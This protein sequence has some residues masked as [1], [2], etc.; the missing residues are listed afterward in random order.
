MGAVAAVQ[1]QVG[2]LA[3]AE[4]PAPLHGDAVQVVLAGAEGDAGAVGDGEA[5]WKVWR[6]PW[7]VRWNRL[8]SI[9]R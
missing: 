3:D 1:A 2:H 7:V 5:A 9:V 6:W 4:P 8:F